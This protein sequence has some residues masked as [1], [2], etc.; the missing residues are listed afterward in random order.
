MAYING[1]DD[2]DVLAYHHGIDEGAANSA[3]NHFVA[4]CVKH[5]AWAD[6]C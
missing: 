6:K 2:G 5:E 4:C 1:V 3:G